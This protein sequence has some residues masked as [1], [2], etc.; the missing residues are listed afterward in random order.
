MHVV[1]SVVAIRTVERVG[2]R[3]EPSELLTNPDAFLLRTDLFK[4]G[5]GRRAVDA[6]FGHCPVIKIPDYAWPM[7]RVG[8][9]LAFISESTYDDRRGDR[10][11]P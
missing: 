10:V 2:R 1:A 3:P 4:L 6:A 9:F 8:D 5:F 7:I 11:R